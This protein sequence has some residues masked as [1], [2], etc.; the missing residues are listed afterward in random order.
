M[1]RRWSVLTRFS[2]FP[3]ASTRSS[4]NHS[5]LSRWLLAARA[6]T[7]LHRNFCRT[8][9]K[10][11]WKEFFLA[12]SGLPVTTFCMNLCKTWKGQLSNVKVKVESEMNII[13]RLWPAGDNFPSKFMQNLERAALKWSI[14]LNLVS[15][16]SFSSDVCLAWRMAIVW[17]GCDIIG[18][19]ILFFGPFSSQGGS[20]T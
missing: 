5:I 10:W 3:E 11:K 12:G 6:V 20:T 19:N 14:L 9:K 8:W 16:I 13:L 1:K 2:I 7:T 17:P 18:K 15:W 4:G